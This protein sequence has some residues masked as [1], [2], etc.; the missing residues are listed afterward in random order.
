MGQTKKAWAP[1]VAF[2]F[3]LEFSKESGFEDQAFMEVSGLTVS[4]ETEELEEGGES[5]FKHRLPKKSTHGNL[6]CKRALSPLK[7]SKLSTWINGI[8][9][10]NYTPQINPC[11]VFISLLNGEGQKVCGWFLTGL[12]PLKWDIGAF[13]SQKNELAVETIEFSY[14]TIERKI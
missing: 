8:V 12:Y 10:G 5:S 1:P 2:Y 11:N 13:N 14:N 6:I 3:N 9:N 4:I 7:D